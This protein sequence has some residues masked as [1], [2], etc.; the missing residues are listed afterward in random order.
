MGAAMYDL[1]WGTAIVGG[2]FIALGL[3]LQKL[4][5]YFS[6]GQD[7]LGFGVVS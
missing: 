2:F 5:I 1:S 7:A 6:A 3:G 4:S